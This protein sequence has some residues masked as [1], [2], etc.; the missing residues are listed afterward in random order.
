MDMVFEAAERII[1]LHF[2]EIITD[3][4][5]QEIK[6]NQKVREIYMGEEENDEYVDA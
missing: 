3:G 5:P 4:T 6:T 2:G 1:V